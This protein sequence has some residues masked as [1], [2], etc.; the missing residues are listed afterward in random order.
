M[1][2]ENIDHIEWLKK[3]ELAS[4]NG[5][6]FRELRADIFADTIKIAGAG[7][8]DL[9]DKHIAI[10]NSDIISEYFDT[11]ITLSK[12]SNGSST[13]VAVIEA[14]CLETANLLIKA[15][16]NPCVVNMAS[17]QNP[18]GGVVNGAGAQ[19][20][21]FFRRSNLFMSLYQYASYAGE[22]GLKQN[23]KQYPLNR[24]V[25]GIYSGNITVFRCSE[26]AGYCLLQEPFRISVVSVA[27]LNHPELDG[28][29]IANVFIEPTKEKIRTILRIA[30]KYEHESLVLSAFGC[31]AF[32]NPPHH[33]AELF[34]DVI[35]EN[36]FANHFKLIVF[37]IIDD[38]N[39][40]KAHNPT[41]NF[42]PFQTVFDGLRKI[43]L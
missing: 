34:R 11:K 2:H 26:R 14:D 33:I 17:A 29:R 13:N 30:A 12:K 35:S 24:E 8:Y 20:E 27:A 25:G 7:A 40:R 41:G 4:K 43:S 36:E 32:C 5:N 38:H 9:N 28:D 18:G 39:S 21:N 31:G 1:L 10:D 37:A 15:G 42:L 3:F 16:Y 22:Y 6:G 23:E 19:E